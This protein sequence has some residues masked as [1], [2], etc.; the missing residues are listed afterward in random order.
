MSLQAS[1]DQ[2][3]VQ[4]PALKGF[5]APLNLPSAANPSFWQKLTGLVSDA[6]LV[7]AAA[8]GEDAAEP[9]LVEPADTA[10]PPIIEEPEALETASP[11][12]PVVLVVPVDP[13]VLMD[14]LMAALGAPVGAALDSITDFSDYLQRGISELDKAVSE[15]FADPFAGFDMPIGIMTASVP[16]AA[17][18]AEEVAKNLVQLADADNDGALSL[19]EATDKVV[20]GQLTVKA[21]EADLG[22]EGKGLTVSLASS[23]EAP[24]KS[25]SSSWQTAFMVAPG[26]AAAFKEQLSSLDPDADGALKPAD[27]FAALDSDKDGSLGEGEAAALMRAP[28]LARA[29]LAEVV[30]ATATEAATLADFQAV[31]AEAPAPA[32]AAPAEAAAQPDVLSK[33]AIPQKDAIPL[34]KGSEEQAVGTEEPVPTEAEEGSG[35]GILRQLDVSECRLAEERLHYN[36]EADELEWD[37]DLAPEADAAEAEAAAVA[38]AP[39]L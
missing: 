26:E 17:L 12:V 20:P 34:P 36:T 19:A 14:G 10:E 25:F 4:A 33:V 8:L 37:A 9:P 7:K 1:K 13:L 22:E 32:E 21:E 15:P 23:F 2:E 39:L 28:E 24:D 35:Q 29:W 3:R 31:L 5:V 18:S 27:L 16:V 11:A 38:A 6:P 30:S